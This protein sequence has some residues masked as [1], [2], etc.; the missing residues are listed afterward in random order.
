MIRKSTKQS[1]FLDT[2]YICERLVPQD[3]FYRKFRELVTPLIKDEHFEDMYCKD[4]G[5]PAISPS[6]LACAMILQMYQDL[7]DREMEEACMYD[8]RI[9]HALGLE[10]DER[11]FDHSS[12]NDFR[13]RLID[14]GQE[15]L[16]FNTILNH[17]IEEGLIKKDEMQRIDATH[18]VAD[19]A[20]PTA[21]RLIRRATF[22][23]LKILKN[24]RKDVWDGIAKEIDMQAY[25]KN[26]INKEI[27][28]KAEDR[29]RKNA[30]VKVVTEAQTVYKHIEPLDLGEK[31]SFRVEMLKEVLNQNVSM[32][33]DG[34]MKMLEGKERPKD[35]Y[36]SP[37]DPD[38][39]F[40]VKSSNNKFVGYKANIT[41]TVESRYITNISATKGNTYD[42]DETIYLV[43]QQKSDNGLSPE[44]LVG[45]GAYGSG[46]NRHRAK[47][48]GTQIIAP[49]PVKNPVKGIYP[50]SMFKYDEDRM[51]VICPQ[52]VESYK[53]IYSRNRGDTTYYFPMQVCEACNRQEK[54]TTSAKG[55]R[56]ITIGLWNREKMEAERYNR[57]RKYLEDI[58]K[59]SLIEAT[60]SEMKNS[61]GMRRARYRGIS[62]VAMQCMYT[63]V[64]VNIKR[65]IGNIQEKLKP[66]NALLRPASCG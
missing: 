64:T 40:G 24:R 35:A 19:I 34:R 53:S 27:P 63:A 25:N 13:Q 56:V 26:R 22:E 42:G 59:R 12:L 55:M 45:D 5:R 6:R 9:K 48:Y 23:V 7:S 2:N 31:F 3:S 8:I 37:V 66:K 51:V 33:E 44:K 58:R 61:H 30:L 29:A 52:G 14:N 49:I 18:I 28:W 50:K 10:I 39:R 16:V 4:N 41:E 38:A 60:N 15:K 62:R 20:V 54:C 32:D 36:V 46:L 57:T 17:L 47:G 11:P 21:I 1:S 43:A 65:W